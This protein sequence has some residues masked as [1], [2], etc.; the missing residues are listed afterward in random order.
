[1]PVPRRK[2]QISRRQ[3]RAIANSLFL[4]ARSLRDAAEAASFPK[5]STPR[6]QSPQRPDSHIPELLYRTCRSDCDAPRDS[7]TEFECR[8]KTERPR[9]EMRRDLKIRNI[10]S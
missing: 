6:P 4:P 3:F 5:R 9:S 10:E 8:N 1:M 2:T 7:T